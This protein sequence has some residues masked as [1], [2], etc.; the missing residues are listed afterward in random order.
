MKTWEVEE[1]VG[2]EVVSLLE[3]EEEHAPAGWGRI[4]LREQYTI[5]P[6]FDQE[7][8]PGKFSVGFGPLPY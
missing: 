2:K 7:L 4:S 5:V 3:K 6:G 8:S 1:S